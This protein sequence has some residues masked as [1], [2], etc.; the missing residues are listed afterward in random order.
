MKM[1][2]YSIFSLT[3]DREKLRSRKVEIEAEVAPASVE[4]QSM[5]SPAKK[6]KESKGSKTS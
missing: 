4:S 1:S 3:S 6:G 5:A 2:M